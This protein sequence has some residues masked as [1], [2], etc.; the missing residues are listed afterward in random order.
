MQD[1]FLARAEPYFKLGWPIFPTRPDKTPCT[2]H[3]LKDATLDRAMIELWSEQWPD[4]NV[5]IATGRKAAIVVVDID[6]EDGEASYVELT[7]QWRHFPETAQARS[8]RGKHLYYSYLP[9]KNSTGRLAPGIDIKGE[10]GA[11]TAP[12][13]L[14]ASGAVYEWIKQPFGFK[15]PL[16]PLWI[17]RAASKPREQARPRNPDIGRLLDEVRSAPNGQRNQ[18]LNRAAFIFGRMVRDGREDESKAMTLLLDAGQAAGLE[19]RE[20]MQTIY[21]GIRSGM[22]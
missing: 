9:I 18:E 21:S 2:E 8:G 13:S 22:R 15:L 6:G 7:K 3:G 11:I 17:V 14:H 12:I 16:L 5:S 4:A 1:T 20:C 10:R 19:R